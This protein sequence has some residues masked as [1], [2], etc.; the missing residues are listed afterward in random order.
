LHFSSLRL[1]TENREGEFS[2]LLDS[3]RDARAT[4]GG[5][6]VNAYMKRSGGFE[7]AI[8]WPDD[9]ILEYVVPSPSD[10]PLMEQHL[11][12]ILQ[13]SPEASMAESKRWHVYSELIEL[14]QLPLDVVP[15]NGEP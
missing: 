2:L 14:D 15:G 5:W 4:F 11:L 10:F 12:R 7:T 8:E 13:N 9:A 3:L 6:G 1:H